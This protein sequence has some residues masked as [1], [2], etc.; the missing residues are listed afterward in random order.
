MEREINIMKLYEMSLSD[1]DCGW[2]DM[3]DEAKV[4]YSN[5]EIMVHEYFDGNKEKKEVYYFNPVK[6]FDLLNNEFEKAKSELRDILDKGISV[7]NIS[8]LIYLDISL[9]KIVSEYEFDDGDFSCLSETEDLKFKDF[10]E[11]DGFD[12]QQ[13]FEIQDE[14]KLV[15]DGE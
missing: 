7:E 1:F 14:R 12:F 4:K 10:I 9:A 15:F 6:Y 13:Y 5:G 11:I 3:L 2:Q 8:R